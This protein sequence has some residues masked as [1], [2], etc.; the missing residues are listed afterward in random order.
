[1]R[2]MMVLVGVALLAACTQN[3][4]VP[5]EDSQLGIGKSAITDLAT[6]EAEMA[7]LLDRLTSQAAGKPDAIATLDR[8]QA[9]WLAYRDAQVQAMW[10]FPAR[11]S[12]GSAYPMC[13]DDVKAQL[14]KIRVSELRAMLEP[15]EGDVCGSQWPN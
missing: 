15:V 5:V 13:V 6:E 12:Y 9:A 2:V 8:V 14:T 3:R 7:R 4:A 10:P 11:A 1:M